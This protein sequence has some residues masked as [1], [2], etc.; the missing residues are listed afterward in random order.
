MRAATYMLALFKSIPQKFFEH[1][2]SA[3]Y[4]RYTKSPARVHL[5]VLINL[6]KMFKLFAF[7]IFFIYIKCKHWYKHS[8]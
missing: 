3:C 1:F 2:L 7:L 6:R 5:A 8:N 4:V